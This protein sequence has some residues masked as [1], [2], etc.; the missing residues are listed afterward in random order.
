MP[1][2]G[3]PRRTEAVLRLRPDF[4]YPWVLAGSHH[5]WVV[6]RSEIRMDLNN[7]GA[8]GMTDQ[9][10]ISVAMN[11]HSGECDFRPGLGTGLNRTLRS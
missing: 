4:A 7:Q 3:K 2:T 5:Q 11:Y 10:L 1:E 9:K 6:L 8:S